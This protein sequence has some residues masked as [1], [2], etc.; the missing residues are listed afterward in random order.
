[1]AIP[2]S[3]GMSVLVSETPFDIEISAREDNIIYGRALQRRAR[4]LPYTYRFRLEKNRLHY[5]YDV[6]PKYIRELIVRHLKYLNIQAYDAGLHE[7][8]ARRQIGL[9][10][11]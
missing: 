4:G 5:Q 7:R 8:K 11:G 1:M 3:K 9:D 10:L 6:P 2:F